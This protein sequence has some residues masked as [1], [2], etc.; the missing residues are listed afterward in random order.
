MEKVEKV[1]VVGTSG[2]AKP[3]ETEVLNI[4]YDT[5][6]GLLRD[7]INVMVFIGMELMKVMVSISI[8]AVSKRYA[9]KE[10]DE[11][12]DPL[13]DM[14][15]KRWVLGEQL[16]SEDEGVQEMVESVD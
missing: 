12:N 13:A 7:T 9:N 6:I 15:K 11:L 3:V 14:V 2:M 16:E 10:K 5:C 8:I 1:A 4:D